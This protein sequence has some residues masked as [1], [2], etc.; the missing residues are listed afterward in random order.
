MKRLSTTD[1]QAAKRSSGDRDWGMGHASVASQTHDMT[2]LFQQQCIE[3]TK[4]TFR[5]GDVFETHSTVY[6]LRD[7]KFI[8]GSWLFG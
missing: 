8:H 3:H 4:T 5:N 2:S 1:D 7:N 6:F